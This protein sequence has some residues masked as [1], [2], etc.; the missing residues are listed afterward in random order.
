MTNIAT[1]HGD[2]NVDPLKIVMFNSY[3]NVYQ[4]INMLDVAKKIGAKR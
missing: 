3:V 4:R 1:E 2:F